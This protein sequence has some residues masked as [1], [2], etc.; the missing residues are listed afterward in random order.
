M[1][2]SYSPKFNISFSFMR[3]R[4]PR[5]WLL[6]QNSRI[7]ISN[8]RMISSEVWSFWLCVY[9][10]THFSVRR[11]SALSLS[12][13]LGCGVCDLCVVICS[14]PH[15]SPAPTHILYWLYYTFHWEKGYCD[16]D[17]PVYRTQPLC[18]WLWGCNFRAGACDCYSLRLATL[19]SLTTVWT[20]VSKQ[21]EVSC[22]DLG[23]HVYGAPTYT[24]AWCMHTQRHTY[25]VGKY[26]SFSML[27]RISIS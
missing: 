19:P 1:F 25:M 20:N 11:R 26:C 18:P 14:I 4:L 9:V 5:V 10:H 17:L 22:I 3:K 13:P 27:C 16:R 21:W 2:S 7:C 6:F 15:Y 12:V 8:G 23:T 24:H